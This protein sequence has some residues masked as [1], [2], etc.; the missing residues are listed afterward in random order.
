M[1][2]FPTDYATAD[3]VLAP[4]NARLVPYVAGLL[5]KFEARQAWETEEDWRAGYNAFAELQVC[6]TKLCARE[7]L[8]KQDQLYRLLDTAMNGAVYSVAGSDP[9]TLEPIITPPI[10][11]VPSTVP[12]LPGLVQRVSRLEALLDNAFNGTLYL[13]YDRVPSIRQ[14]LE[15]IKTQL[16]ALGVELAEKG[17]LDDDMLIELGKVVVAL[18]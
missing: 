16:S 1:K 12:V 9:I 14:E 11:D 5:K 15:Q 18:A 13:E 4:M 10:P 8:K 6:M 7:L 17:E 3:C 2:T